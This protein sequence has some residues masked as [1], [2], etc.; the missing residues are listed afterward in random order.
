MQ[1][2]QQEGRLH[3]KGSHAMLFKA[4]SLDWTDDLKK[5]KT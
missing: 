2:V 1:E 3:A 5:E 4:D